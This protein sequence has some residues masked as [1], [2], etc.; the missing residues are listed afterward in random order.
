MHR[1]GYKA[2]LGDYLPKVEAALQHV[3]AE[4]LVK[5]IWAKDHTVWSPDPTEITNRL[6]W[7][8]VTGHV[9]EQL[10]L[11]NCLAQEIRNDGYR[12]ILLVG[13]GGSSLGSEVLRQ[14]IGSGPGYPQLIVLDSTLPAWIQ[15][16]VNNIDLRKTLFLISSK[17][18]TT[19][20]TMS[21]YKFFRG[22]AEQNAGAAEQNFIAITSPGTPLDTLARE[23][24]FRHTILNPEDVGSRYS[25]LSFL[26]M[27]PAALAGMDVEKLTNLADSVRDQCGAE[28]PAADNPGAWLGTVMATLALNGRDKLTLITSPAFESFGLWAEQLLA[29]STGKEAK[30]II[31]IV[32]EPP[33][34]PEHYGEDRFFVFMRLKGDANANLEQAMEMIASSGNPWVSIEID[35]KYQVGAEFYRWQFAT[36]VAGAILKIQ[37]FDQPNVQVAKEMTDSVLEQYRL[38]GSLPPIKATISVPALMAEAK[39]GSYVAIMAYARQTTAMDEALA[40]LRRRITERYHVPVTLGYGPRILHSTGQM[41]KGGPNTGL[42][43]QITTASTLD[44]EIP[45]EDFSFGILVQAQATGDLQVLQAIDRRVAHIYLNSVDRASLDA[46]AQM[47]I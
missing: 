27:A 1:A 12:H 40:Q 20:E 16:V 29:E 9:R 19:L 42:F 31:P 17:S 45:G 34:A 13:M 25:V 28:V 22:L 33:M 11:L 14:V 4:D 38:S 3:Q 35:D 39:P 21:F 15:S 26:G 6:G 30:G 18:G 37:P 47:P 36:A 32:G 41:H 5:R 43:I 46:L 7:L 24:G 2:D 8:T 10:G 23:C 44:L